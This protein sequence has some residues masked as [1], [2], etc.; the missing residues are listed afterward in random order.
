MERTTSTLLGLL[1]CAK[2]IAQSVPLNGVVV[3]Q[4]SQYETG[5]R[6][7][8]KD[9]SIRSAFAKPVVSDRDG[10]F[11]LVLSGV[12]SGAPVR[13]DVRK[14]GLE[15]VNSQ[16]LEAVVLGRNAILEVVMADPAKLAD[17]RMRFYQVATTTIEANYER[18]MRSLRDEQRTLQVRLD[19]IGRELEDTLTS[20]GEAMDALAIQRETALQRADDLARTFAYVDLDRASERYRKA[21]EHLRLGNVDSVLVMLDKEKLDTE[22]ADARNK[23]IR[24]SELIAAANTSI[25]QL[26]NSYRLKADVLRL[27]LDLGGSL[28]ALERM[29]TIQEENTDVLGPVDRALLLRDLGKLQSRLARLEP[30][31]NSL[32]ESLDL[33]IQHNGP[34]HPEVS[35]AR[36]QMAMLHEEE[37]D[38]EQAMA[39]YRAAL[40]QRL[41]LVDA[42]P[43]STIEPL[44]G[45]GNVFSAIGEYDSALVY[46][47]RALDVLRASGR[48]GTIEEAT[49]T[50][51][52][53]YRLD[54][55]GRYEEAMPVYLK[56]LALR[57]TLITQGVKE[58]DLSTAYG[59]LGYLCDELA[60]YDNA[61]LYYDSCLVIEERLYG[62]EH[63]LP[64]TTVNNIG[65]VLSHQG[66]H[67][68]ALDKYR[69]AMAISERL[70]G[71]D[72]FQVGLGHNNIASKL[73]DLGKRKEALPHFD[74][75]L[76][77]FRANLGPD[78]PY[79]ATVLANKAMAL[80]S[81]GDGKA[82]MDHYRESL[83]IRIATYGV[84]HDAVADAYS[85][86]GVEWT[87]AGN[88][89]SALFHLKNALAIGI[90]V[91]GPEHANN[92]IV[93]E[94]LAN[95]Y[96]LAG[97]TMQ[98]TFYA[99]RALAIGAAAVGAD[100]PMLAPCKALLAACYRTTGK[101]NEALV[102]ATE[103]YSNGTNLQGAWV[104]HQLA[105]DDGDDKAA[106]AH[107]LQCM[108]ALGTEGDEGRVDA[109][110][111]RAAFMERAT[112]AGRVDLIERFKTPH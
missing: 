37:G 36:I 61:L 11:A 99:E 95:A 4:N 71:P 53:A 26:F 57:K 39:M 56:S 47:T 46:T 5:K 32:Q 23:K 28:T 93:H 106:L 96:L 20:L 84:S 111:V 82:A 83:R 12:P 109:K 9:A 78:H 75:A 73:D 85:G 25:R 27:S 54:N 16:E 63:T 15:V 45:I 94:N 98:A 102:L 66:D 49:L 6:Q 14:N 72:H 24:G 62:K 3:I 42:E 110:V 87:R 88:A 10:S 44:A 17:A 101:R 97:D 70:L 22:Y 76:R 38:T 107:L 7:Y 67:Q 33:F 68:G 13:I 65:R 8:V 21:Y 19:D 69:T 90:A 40:D 91:L 79:V 108:E 59:N 89:D 103:S 41:A 60:Q 100:S 55:L 51:S 64:A 74:E 29:R 81:V 105:V 50:N 34:D 48:S 58:V 92:G 52:L 35:A 43:G 86:L 1:L 112:A 77:I 18:R 80:G 2:V 31:H 104:L 30:A